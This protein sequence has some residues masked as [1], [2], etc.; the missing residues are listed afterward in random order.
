M[1]KPKNHKNKDS[2]HSFQRIETAW[3]SHVQRPWLDPV[4]HKPFKEMS[5]GENQRKKCSSSVYWPQYPGIDLTCICRVLDVS[6]A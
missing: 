4:S 6:F 3:L 2:A 1:S 5:D